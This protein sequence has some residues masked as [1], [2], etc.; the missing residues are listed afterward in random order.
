MVRI[1]LDDDLRGKRNGLNE[2]VDLCD[3][4]GRSVGRFLPAAMYDDLWYAA[5]A[6]RT[7]EPKEELR[8][9]HREEDGRT[10]AEIWTSLGRT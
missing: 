3:D 2:P 10:L 1:T 6:E 9:S 5:L 4:T 8:R 7:G